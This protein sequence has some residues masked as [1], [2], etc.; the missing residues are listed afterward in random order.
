MTD[1]AAGTSDDGQT[2]RRQVGKLLIFIAEGTALDAPMF[3]GTLQAFREVTP[4]S[5]Q[6]QRT[7]F[8]MRTGRGDDGSLDDELLA[9]LRHAFKSFGCTW[10]NE[11]E[12]FSCAPGGGDETTSM[13]DAQFAESVREDD[14]V[15]RRRCEGAEVCSGPSRT[16]EDRMI[17]GKIP[18]EVEDFGVAL[19]EKDCFERREEFG[20]R[21]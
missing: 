3:G 15:V 8:F 4:I 21:P 7:F 5:T 13:S 11:D 16:A 20:G 10:L 14:N 1:D 17:E 2:R 18:T 19:N 9:Q 12:K 6:Q